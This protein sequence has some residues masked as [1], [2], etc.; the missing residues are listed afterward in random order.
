MELIPATQDP[1]GKELTEP[2]I[3]RVLRSSTAYKN[4]ESFF[5]GTEDTDLMWDPNQYVNVYVFTF[6]E[7]NVTG[8][9]TLPFTPARTV[10]PAWMQITPIIQ[11]FRQLPMALL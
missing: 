3:H 2:G 4:S 6:V 9:T 5:K 8:R 11:S 10:C 7:S 1:D